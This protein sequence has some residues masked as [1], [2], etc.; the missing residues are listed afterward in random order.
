[1]NNSK[2]SPKARTMDTTTDGNEDGYFIPI[3]HVYD[4]VLDVETSF[5]PNIFKFLQGPDKGVG[6]PG[7]Y[8]N[9][10]VLYPSE[11]SISWPSYLPC[12]RQS[13]HWKIAEMMTKEL[14]DAIYEGSC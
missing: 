10:I 1:M 6:E 5:D 14:L 12:C 9:S 7:C 8:S 3:T 11:L 2:S 4:P 13:K